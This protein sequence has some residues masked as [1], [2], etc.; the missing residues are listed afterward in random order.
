HAQGAIPTAAQVQDIVNFQTSLRTAQAY[1][2]QAGQLNASGATGGPVAL[3]SQQFFI[4][5][6]DS[7]PPS[8]GFNPTGA[9][10]TPTI[11]NLFAAWTNSHFP[12][13]ASIARG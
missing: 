13:N 1:D 7:F 2:Y 11:F 12:A 9:A 4:G 5:I 8:F 3:A 6:N 10:F